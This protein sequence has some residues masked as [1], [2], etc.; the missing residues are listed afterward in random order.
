MQ[1]L[2]AWLMILGF[3]TLGQIALKLT[4]RVAWSWPETLWPLWLP[5][6]VI[7]A[8]G[9]AISAVYGVCRGVRWLAK[10]FPMCEEDT[11]DAS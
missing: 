10:R 9:A 3:G 5:S 8:S 7:V 11:R 1:R 6:L 4:D 2:L